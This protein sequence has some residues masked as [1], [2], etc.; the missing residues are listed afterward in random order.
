MAKPKKAELGWRE[1]KTAA[2]RGYGYK[3]QKARETFLANPENVL[4]VMCAEVGRVTEATVVDHRIPH[5]GDMS[6]FWDRSNWQ[7]LCK[8]CHD[9]HKQAEE[10]GSKRRGVQEDGWPIGA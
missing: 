1:G 5:R 9:S 4:C 2:Q 7:P 3:W 10:K 6:L 8:R